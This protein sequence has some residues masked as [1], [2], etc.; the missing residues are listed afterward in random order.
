MTEHGTRRQYQ[1]HRCR[2][3][4]CRAAEATYRARLRARHA[5]QQPILGSHQSASSTWRMIHS[6]HAEGFTH[7]AIASLIGLR[8]RKLQ[9]DT[10]RVTLR[11]VLRV[12]HVFRTRFCESPAGGDMA[13]SLANLQCPPRPSGTLHE[14]R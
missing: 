10:E 13:F 3:T 12:H 1:R 5:H 9:F 4:P 14:G 6:L 8:T 11:T 7:G 2:C